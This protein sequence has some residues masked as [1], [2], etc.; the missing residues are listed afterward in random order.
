MKE[1]N[2][3]SAVILF[4][5]VAFICFSC[6]DD[7][8]SNQD[9]ESIFIEHFDMVPFTNQEIDCKNFVNQVSYEG[10]SYAYVNNHCADFAYWYIIDCNGET[11]CTTQETLCNNIFWNG[12]DLG[13]I[14]I[15]E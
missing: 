13:I 10:S 11:L 8:G 15:E 9:C 4:N 12:E 2:L 1:L 7:E 3:F 6:N 5:L 14:G